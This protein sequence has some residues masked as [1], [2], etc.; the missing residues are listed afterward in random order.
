VKRAVFDVNG[1]PVPAIPVYIKKKRLR[2]NDDVEVG[3]FKMSEL[4]SGKYYVNFTVLDSEKNEISSTN[5]AFFIHN[6]DVQVVDRNTLPIDVQMASSEIAMLSQED[7]DIMLNATKFL[8]DDEDIKLINNLD[9]DKAKRSFLYRFWKE[10][11]SN[12][13]TPTLEN[14][15]EMLKRV[16]FSTANFSSIKSKGWESDRGRVLIKYGQPSEIQYYANVAEFKEFQAWS[17][18]NIESGVVF[19]FGVLGAFGNL[20]LIH[21]TKTGELH[22]DFWFDLIKISEGQTGM[23]QDGLSNR[24]TLREIFQRNNLEMP[25]YL[26]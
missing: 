2:G 3:M 4:S 6:P 18:D 16:Q 8:L 1:L 7:L 26:K 5:T 23:Q 17:Y 9:K 20:Q 15:R 12:P 14:Y 19:I 25:R 24:S 21:S 22:N 13:N 10:R 11:D